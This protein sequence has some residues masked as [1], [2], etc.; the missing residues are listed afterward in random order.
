MAKKVMKLVKLQIP[1]G[2]ASPAPPVGPALGQAGVNIMGFCKE[3]NAR[4]Q[5]QAGMI[6]PVVITVF[7]DR[8]FT[9]I[10]KTPPAPV[11]LK[12]AAGLDK[13]SGEPNKNKVGSVTRDQVKE[14]AE[15]KMQDLNAADVEAAMRM[16]E[17]TARSMGITIQD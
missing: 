14:I 17:G 3:F 12:K 15:V 13:A 9:F 11:L 7:E 5:E 8:S 6:I 16:V 4:T 1:A 10:T 2:K